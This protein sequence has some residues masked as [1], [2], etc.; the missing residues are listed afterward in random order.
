M[1]DWNQFLSLRA[2]D[3][4]YFV[5]RAVEYAESG[6]ELGQFLTAFMGGIGG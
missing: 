2:R 3:R 5:T 6:G 1:G 4:L